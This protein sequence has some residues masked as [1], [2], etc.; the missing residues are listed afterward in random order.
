M[1]ALNSLTYLRMF[2]RFLISISC[3]LFLSSESKTQL[4]ENPTVV[5]ESR[6]AEES[7]NNDAYFIIESLP[8]WIV[9]SQLIVDNKIE[10]KYEVEA[11]LNP[12]YLEEDFNGDH[13]MDLAVCIKEIKSGKLGFAIIHGKSFEVH[14][15][16]AGT[17]VEDSLSD[18]LTY[19]KIWKINREKEI[20]GTD[21]DENG[22]LTETP[23][24][25]LDA[26]S[27]NIIKPEVGGG[28]IYWNGSE[29]VYLHQSC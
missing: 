6:I 4:N 14:I 18:D 1:I 25:I 27:I 7:L 23:A 16:G 24:V 3:F 9:D 26:P 28:V 12:F 17:K 20:I 2:F 15:I 8:D 11:R 5:V 22:D 21:V 19:I 10:H 29:Y 13:I